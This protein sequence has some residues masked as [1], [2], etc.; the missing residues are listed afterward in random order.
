MPDPPT[1]PDLRA[2][3]DSSTAGKPLLDQL[4]ANPFFTAVCLAAIAIVT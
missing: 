2:L 4:A 1:V 3:L